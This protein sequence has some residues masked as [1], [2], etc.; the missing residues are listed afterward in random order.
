MIKH[1]VIEPLN[2]DANTVNGSAM[3]KAP[4]ISSHAIEDQRSVAL[5]ERGVTG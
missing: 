2:D 1:Q 5:E 3:V 4:T